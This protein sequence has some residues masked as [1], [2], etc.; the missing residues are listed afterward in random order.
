M[1][2]ADNLDLGTVDCQLLHA[3]LSILRALGIDNLRAVHAMAPIPAA[4]KCPD[5]DLSRGLRTHP[6]WVFLATSAIGRPT[7]TMCT[8]SRRTIVG[9][10]GQRAAI[11]ESGST[12]AFMNR[13]TTTP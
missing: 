13:Y 7:H 2:G 1:A 12:T 5:V 3:I 4:S 8:R 10:E 11:C 9:H 6:S